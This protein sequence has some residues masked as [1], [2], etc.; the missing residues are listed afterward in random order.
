MKAIGKFI[1]EILIGIWVVIAIF[2]TI[3]LLSSNDYGV[4]EFGDSSLFIVDN[5]TLEQYGFNK[6]DIVIV[7]KGLETEYNT[8]DGVF[9][10][11][12]NEETNS[13]VN[14][15]IITNVERVNRAEDAFYFEDTA[16]SYGKILGLA[17]GCMKIQKLG[18]ILGLLES[19][20]GFMFLIILPTLYAVVFEIYTILY[21]VSLF[22]CF[23]VIYN[24]HEK[25]KISSMFVRVL[26][27]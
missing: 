17:N 8:N 18:L 19:R 5:R 6:N 26:R 11:S 27:W 2:T 12:G 15:G 24:K 3:C 13:F 23:C 14:F 4:S 20:W 7:K 25:E 9:F 1:K 21:V 10:Y 16:V 22:S